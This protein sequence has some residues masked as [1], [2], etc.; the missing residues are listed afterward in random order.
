MVEESKDIKYFRVLKCFDKTKQKIQTHLTGDA[1][2]AWEQYAL[3][4]LVK[5]KR[6][7]TFQGQAPRSNNERQVLKLL[8][9]A[10]QIEENSES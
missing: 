6:F 7:K 3:P 8:K 5:D 9:D 1:L 4:V 2:N 10:G